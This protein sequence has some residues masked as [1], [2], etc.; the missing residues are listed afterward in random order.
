MRGLS[1]AGAGPGPGT[2]E[3]QGRANALHSKPVKGFYDHEKVRRMWLKEEEE[4][5]MNAPST[6]MPSAIPK[7]PDIT[8]KAYIGPSKPILPRRNTQNGADLRA[9]G[10]YTHR[11]YC[12][13]PAKPRV[14]YPNRKPI[15]IREIPVQKVEPDLDWSILD[16]LNKSIRSPTADD[17][18]IPMHSRLPSP[19]ADDWNL[20]EAVASSE[21]PSED[22]T[23]SITLESSVE[24]NCT[25]PTADFPVYDFLEG[26]HEFLNTKNPENSKISYVDLKNSQKSSPTNI[27][28]ALQNVFAN[29]YQTSSFSC[30]LPQR[31]TQRAAREKD[32]FPVNCNR[33][34]PIDG[35]DDVAEDDGKPVPVNPRQFVRILRR[36]EMRARQEDSGVIPVERQA[37]LYESRHQHALSRVRLSDGRFD[38]AAR[39]NSGQPPTSE[40]V[41]TQPTLKRQYTPIRPAHSDQDPLPKPSEMY[42]TQGPQVPRLPTASIRAPVRQEPPKPTPPPPKKIQSK[43]AIPSDPQQFRPKISS[44]YRPQPSRR[45]FPS[46]MS[47]TARPAPAKPDSSKPAVQMFHSLYQKIPPITST[48]PPHRPILERTMAN[49]VPGPS[50]VAQLRPTGNTRAPIQTAPRGT[51][52]IEIRE[53]S[54]EFLDSLNM[55]ASEVTTTTLPESLESVLSGILE[56]FSQ[57]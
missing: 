17:L 55:L 48:N 6:S 19:L 47:T 2:A 53:E 37:Y 14:G 11:P 5:S 52:N 26:F 50:I 54:S 57:D 15:P 36:R 34:S 22:A 39:K 46:L 18:N 45:T 8:T 10:P 28:D 25:S 56:D 31:Y 3:A 41:P 40:I 29:T 7:K 33:V 20:L 24:R 42:R 12:L 44:I 35:T 23:T 30:N 21:G 1:D 32:R 49:P 43:P 27:A 13:G 4:G 16:R 38:P 51:A 9:P